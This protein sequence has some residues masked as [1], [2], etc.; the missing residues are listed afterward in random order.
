MFESSLL[1]LLKSDGELNE[2]ISTYNDDSAIFSDFAPEDAELPYIVFKIDR[3]PSDHLSIDMF[4]IYVDYFDRG[5]SFVKAREASERIEFITDTKQ[6][7]HERYDKIRLYR[8]SAGAVIETDPKE[9]HYNNQITARASRK[10]W[11]AQL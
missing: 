5:T 2:L 1:V 11:M 8:A 10:K 7:T 9:I 4:N 3:T 6:L